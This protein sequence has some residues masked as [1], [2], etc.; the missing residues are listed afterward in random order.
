MPAPAGRLLGGS[1]VVNGFAFL[2][3]S[4]ANIEAWAGLGNPGWDWTSFSKSMSRFGL[5]GSPKAAEYSP[6]QLTIPDEDTEWPRVWRETLAKLGFPESTDPFSERILG[7]VMGPE[8]IGLDKKRSFS[9]N[10]YLSDSVRSR[11][12]LTI[13]PKAVAQKILFEPETLIATAVQVFNA[14]D[15]DTSTVH[16]RKEIVISAGAIN[17]PR[18]LELSGV[19]NAELL[20]SLVIDVLVHNPNVGENLQNH[21]MCSLSFETTGG[22]GFQTID[23]LLRKDPEAVAAAQNAYAKGTGPA[24]RS[25]LNVLAQ[26]PLPDSIP[27][28]QLLDRITPSDTKT[29]DTI[30]KA[31]ESFVHYILTS[32]SEASGCYMTAPG[33]V[34]FADDG[35][36]V[37]PPPG[38]SEFFTIA[39][40][41]AHPLSRGSVHV[42]SPSLTTSPNGVSIDPKYF[43]HPLD[44]EILARH[45]QL[46]EM[47]AMTEPLSSHLKVGG[48][49]GPDMPTPGGF[50]DLQVAKDF[51]VKRA[52]GAHH[53]TG[54]CSMMPREL[55]GV[56][57]HELRV[58]G[59]RNLRICDASIMPISPR[60]NIQGVVYAAAEHGAQI[61]KA[62]M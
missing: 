33:F 4:A 31:Q 46:T 20:Q 24:S 32:P 52:K 38:T 35:S 1:S 22:D 62:T 61:I 44:L 12:N 42:T 51:L 50:A 48:Q 8:T 45:V 27:L 5:S 6:L 21:P 23:K 17:S 3:N 25:N 26:L 40:H 56:V 47:I 53:W 2:P 39:V 11:S 37:P 14:Q 59:C 28:G 41:L 34:S 9:A 19:G 43:S 29:I 49:R 30:A 36:S 54:S 10:A 60:S 16:A 57:D 58:Y 18:L 13:W 7:S 55:G 15:Q